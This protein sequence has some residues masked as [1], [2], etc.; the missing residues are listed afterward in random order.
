MPFRSA[1]LLPAVVAALLLPAA[2]AQAGLP[3]YVVERATP[4]ISLIDS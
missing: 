1:R 4:A 2:S 3:V